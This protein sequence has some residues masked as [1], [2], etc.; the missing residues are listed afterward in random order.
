MPV[1]IYNSGGGYVL[2]GFKASDTGTDGRKC[3]GVE[4]EGSGPKNVFIQY[5]MRSSSL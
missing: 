4:N 5:S 2:F 3:K 1:F